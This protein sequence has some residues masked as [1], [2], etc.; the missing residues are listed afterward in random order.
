M[1]KSLEGTLKDRLFKKA[2]TPRLEMLGEK[3]VEVSDL[4]FEYDV[5]V[6]MPEKKNSPV[7]T[8]VPPIFKPSSA[9][10]ELIKKETQ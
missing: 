2:P 8:K 5:K 1:S 3:D 6:K 4:S 7:K 10:Q 9:D